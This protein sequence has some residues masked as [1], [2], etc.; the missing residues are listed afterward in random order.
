VTTVRAA[1]AFAFVLAA[2][3]A[4]FAAGGS[5]PPRGFEGRPLAEALETLRARGLNLIF[6]SE[7]VRPGLVVAEEPTS[8]DPRTALDQILAPFGLRARDGAS[9][10]I[11]VVPAPGPPA[12]RAAPAVDDDAPLEPDPRL[13][14]DIVV[15]PGLHE[16]VPQDPGAGRLLDRDAIVAAP[17]LGNDPSRMVS[18]LPGVA[19]TEGSAEFNPRGGA[20]KD[21]SLVLDGLELYDPFHLSAFRSPFSF[22]D[23]RMIDSINLLG[24]G[25]TADRGD[26]HGGFLEMSSLA[27][28]DR[29]TTELEAGTLNSRVA[30][31]TVTPLGPLLVSGR[32]LYPDVTADTTAFGRDGLRP[33][34]ADLYVKLGMK[35]GANT[36]LSG[37][38]LLAS[39]RA[40]LSE[41]DGSENVDAAN[42]SAYF[43]L[44]AV[45]SWSSGA[46][47]DSVL[48][49]GRID[50]SRT[51]LAEP[52]DRLTEVRDHREVRFVG[53]K[54]DATWTLG[55]SHAVRGGLDLHLLRANLMH[56]AGPPDAET[57]LAVSPAGASIGAYVAYRVALSRRVTTEAGLRW[58]RQ[59][60]TGDREWSPRLNL[61]WQAAPRSELRLG[62]GRYAQSLRIH[63]LRIEDGER[64]Y[65]SP[66]NSRQVDLTFVQRFT[67][68]W[69]FRMDAYRHEL[70]RLQPRY[71]NVFHPLELFPEVEADR[72]L[73]A[74]KSA[75]LQG[76]ELSVRGDAGAPLQWMVNYTWSSAADV[77]SGVEVPR[78][79]DQTHAGNVFVAYGWR[80][81]WFLSANA[82]VHTGWPTTP[83]TGRAVSLPDG[84]TEIE[85]VSGPRNS[86]RFPTYARLDL[87]TGR[88]FVTAKGSLRLDLTI[89]NVT[90]RENVCC[91]DEVQFQARPDGGIETFTSYDAWMGITPSF[92]V[93]WS[94]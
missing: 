59:T 76:V 18:L 37:H 60:Y 83:V 10:A 55:G 19:S 79:W 57:T 73:V 49:A 84:L 15:V 74:P 71:E 11:L 61:A 70:D 62:L 91:V 67:A 81:G 54:S 48:S 85:P 63:E 75:R 87:K 30:H 56:A 36:R 92:Q 82:N 80:S 53:L 38:A 58:D 20:A 42:G 66:E 68:G 52:D 3:S 26:R 22:V 14:E 13:V 5:D 89:V 8:P 47:T 86:A 1:V 39:D 51:G 12:R 94:F 90:D 25:F 64:T 35:A 65:R 17:A 72:V 34:F 41:T 33:T 21:V 28:I 93:L 9:G 44:R 88:G 23:G 16:I 46:E 69:S 50:R 4:R 24:G 6:S 43:W 27:A 78:S 29:T 40:T 32:Y 45:R 31:A 77:V 7:I 2:G